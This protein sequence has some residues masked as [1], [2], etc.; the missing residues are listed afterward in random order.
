[1]FDFSQICRLKW[2][3]RVLGVSNP[4]C[5]GPC[6]SRFGDRM[7]GLHLVHRR[8]DLPTICS[9]MHYTDRHSSVSRGTRP[10]FPIMT[11]PNIV[12]YTCQACT[13]SWTHLLLLPQA[14]WHRC[15][16]MRLGCHMMRRATMVQMGM[17]GWHMVRRA[18][19]V[20]MPRTLIRRGCRRSTWSGGPLRSKCW[21][22]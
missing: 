7:M 12:R 10:H 4:L 21:G 19:K 17:L 3:L 11:W 16:K 20:K 6:A 8:R 15:W 5:R 22:P 18:P 14:R 1:M 13:I 9:H 2:L